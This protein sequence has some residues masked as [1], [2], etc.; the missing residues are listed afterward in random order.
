MAPERLAGKPIGQQKIKGTAS[1]GLSGKAGIVFCA[2][3]TGRLA[4][5]PGISS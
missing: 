3:E 1:A 5:E 4:L 2:Q